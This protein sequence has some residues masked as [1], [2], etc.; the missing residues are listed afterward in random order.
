MPWSDRKQTKAWPADLKTPEQRL[1]ALRRIGYR[2]APEDEIDL[3]LSDIIDPIYLSDESSLDEAV[4]RMGRYV[5][6][7]IDTALPERPVNVNPAG[8]YNP[9]RQAP[10]QMRS[11]ERRPTPAPGPVRRYADIQAP[12]IPPRTPP[13]TVRQLRQE[14]GLPQSPEP[15]YDEVEPPPPPTTPP[16]SQG[17]AS[18]RDTAEG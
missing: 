18:P 16:P 15:Y 4:D 6:N 12:K 3:F 8:E 11:F 5:R 7:A 13:K 17:Q 14:Q 10:T 2:I 1:E 9:P